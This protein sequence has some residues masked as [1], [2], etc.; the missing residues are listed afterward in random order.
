M[1][2]HN[3]VTAYGLC[4]SDR[5]TTA[6]IVNTGQNNHP[7]IWLFWNIFLL[8][9]PS[10]KAEIHDQFFS[11]VFSLELKFETFSDVFTDQFFLK[12]DV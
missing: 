4:V 5:Q 12:N 11:S 1:L 2:Y 3:P 9:K 6:R 7:F 10:L 8:G